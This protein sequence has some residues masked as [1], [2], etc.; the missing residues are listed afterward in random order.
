VIKIQEKNN[1]SIPRGEYPRP[2]A[3]RKD[4]ISLNGT[5]NFEFDP[6]HL[7]FTKNWHITPQLSRNIT[8]PFVFQSRLS[9][10]N[11][12]EFIDTVWY[13]RTF[14][15]PSQYHQKHVLL[16]FGAVDYEC[17]VF[18]NGQFVGHH[19]GGLSAFAY[20]I[21]AYL[22]SDRSKP[23]QLVVQVFDPPFD[24]EIPRGKQSVAK[25]FSGCDY[26]KVT[27][28]WQSVW[29]EFIAEAYLDRSN[30]QIKTNCKTG[31]ISASISIENKT[32]IPF[33]V[34]AEVF[35][36]EKSISESTLP[37]G[38]NL[39]NSRHMTHSTISLKVDPSKIVR[40][41][42]SNPKLY[43]VH[44]RLINGD[45][46]DETPVDEL[47]CS[48]GFRTIEIKGTQLLLN[49]EPI[50]LKMM[51][52][53]GYWV[54]S[55]W[56]APSDEA[57]KKDMELTLEMGFNA[58][59]LHQKV[60]DPRLLYWADTMGII[61]WGETANGF[62]SVRLKDRF[63]NE[64]GQT[65]RRDRN[66]PSIIAWVPVNESW[67]S[68][69]LTI[70]EN[71]EWLRSAYYLTKAMDDTR[72][73]IDND[74]WEHVITDICTIHDYSKPDMYAARYPEKKPAN[75]SDYLAK[76][77]PSRRTYVE[78]EAPKGDI[79]VIISEWGG[80]GM[81][82]DEPDAKPDHFRCWGYQGVL[83]KTFDEVLAL[84]EATIRELAKRKEWIIGH[85]YTE[86]NDQY[87]EMNGF[88][89][90]DRRPKADLKRIKA[91]N[92]LI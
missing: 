44:F 57:I 41:S 71:Q 24:P 89:T 40:W 61:L 9:G 50:Y 80:W 16:N 7:G 4:W 29:L 67:G 68:G 35:D 76:L 10:I 42:P 47:I 5:W 79:P 18:I 3:K 48:F 38:F 13:A 83:Y 56:T 20:D 36:G 21:T 63:M 64:W 75:L 66:H 23:Q 78:G 37:T 45:A 72:P 87:Q 6:N 22:T 55:L 81:F 28:I 65:V 85:C 19:M 77:N 8:V 46:D 2:E 92:D 69:D 34:E 25:R 39:F 33:F 51:L 60:E 58:L 86:W 26:E 43:S 59:R 82:F 31:E 49:G 12:Q 54:D 1:N 88:L 53:Q 32:E 14:E 11:S 91:I 70:K 52:Y 74:G 62:G 15:I 27:G 73:V 30:V 17:Q 90:F 84:Y